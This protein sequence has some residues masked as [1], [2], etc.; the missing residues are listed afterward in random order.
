MELVTLRINREEFL[1]S[2]DAKKRQE[3]QD[4]AE[5]K[6]EIYD[7]TPM[8]GCVVDNV[9]A[10][11]IS[12]LREAETKKTKT[13]ETEI[14]KFKKALVFTDIQA[15]IKKAGF[16][17]DGSPK[18]AIAGLFDNKVDFIIE[19]EK[20][21]YRSSSLL[22]SL[23]LRSDWKNLIM[24][25]VGWAGVIGSKAIGIIGI[26][27]S[28]N[29]VVDCV[30]A[31]MNGIILTFAALTSF[32]VLVVNPAYYFLYL[33]KNN[34]KVRFRLR[35]GLSVK[36]PVTPKEVL[37]QITGY[38]PFAILFEV[39]KGWEKIEQDPVILRVI[40][41]GDKQFFEPGVGYNMTPLEKKSLV[42]M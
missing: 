26:I 32:H 20:A 12:E 13:E 19:H 25:M 4:K 29:N 39:A 11:K 36:V 5:Y 14:E 3:R 2:I 17:S 9:V 22:V 35:S 24:L 42:E 16:H 41:I 8:E 27:E 28:D 31:I 34:T 15:T 38:G 10:D 23:G 21:K 6:V 33:E 7:P 1:A 37:S 18:V 30:T 40:T